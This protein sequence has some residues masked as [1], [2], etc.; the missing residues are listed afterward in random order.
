M[1]I[2]SWASVFSDGG[3]TALN[4]SD[5]RLSSDCLAAFYGVGAPYVYWSC[6]LPRP[7]AGGCYM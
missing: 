1:V 5:C 6:E 2:C 7:L 3:D 4:W